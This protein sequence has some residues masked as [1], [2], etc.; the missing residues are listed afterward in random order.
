MQ[1]R[2]SASM[3]ALFGTTV[4]NRRRSLLFLSDE[5]I[6]ARPVIIYSKAAKTPMTKSKRRMTHAL[7]VR[8]EK[9]RYAASST[10]GSRRAMRAAEKFSAIRANT[11]VRA[12][13]SPA[14]SVKN[15]QGSIK[16]LTIQ[17]LH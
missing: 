8:L 7:I 17:K 15:M 10:D 6:C 11:D 16:L 13:F 4:I 1:R 3:T 5:N 9:F 2:A 14:W 12:V